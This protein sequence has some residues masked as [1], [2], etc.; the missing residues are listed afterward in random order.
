MSITPILRLVDSKWRPTGR[1]GAAPLFV[2]AE[3]LLEGPRVP[4]R[5]QVPQS[6]LGAA[7]QRASRGRWQFG[8]RPVNRRIERSTALSAQATY[9]LTKSLKLYAEGT[10]AATRR[11]TPV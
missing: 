4:F 5:R 11:L 7:V 8:L 1:V 2:G 3:T 9:S 10:V 6:V